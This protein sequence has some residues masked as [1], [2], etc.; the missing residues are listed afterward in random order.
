MGSN[1]QLFF[2]AWKPLEAPYKPSERYRRRQKWRYFK[3][4]GFQYCVSVGNVCI[5]VGSVH[6]IV[7]NTGQWFLQ[8][9]KLRPALF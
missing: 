5:S 2:H 9:D 4:T 6:Q 7:F 3:G 1:L 8:F